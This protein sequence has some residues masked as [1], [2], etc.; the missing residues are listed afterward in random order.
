MHNATFVKALQNIC[1]KKEE[2]EADLVLNLHA[3]RQMKWN[4]VWSII[5]DKKVDTHASTNRK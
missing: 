4:H 2:E 3:E 5:T 1:G